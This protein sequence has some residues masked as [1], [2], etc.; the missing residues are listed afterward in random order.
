MS[1]IA[2][3]T[4]TLL[5][6][7]EEE[8]G[9]LAKIFVSFLQG[10][11]TIF[12]VGDLGAGKTTFTKKVAQSLDIDPDKVLSPTFVLQRQY[13]GTFR[14]YH[15]DLYRLVDPKQLQDIG[16]FETLAFPGLKIIEWADRFPS[17]VKYADY[18]VS[19]EVLENQARKIVIQGMES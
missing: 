8:L 2:K 6:N 11:E 4:I 3:K 17:I 1:D 10:E 19:I 14:I 12:L 7:T 16:F 5:L 13:E 15:F 9:K 18:I